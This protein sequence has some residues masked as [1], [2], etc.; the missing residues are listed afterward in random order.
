MSVN[1]MVLSLNKEALSVSKMALSISK[2]T[3]FGLET[4]SIIRRATRLVYQAT[5]HTDETTK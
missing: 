5:D 2:M 3:D 4:E 1:K